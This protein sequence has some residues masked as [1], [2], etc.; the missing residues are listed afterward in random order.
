MATS[1]SSRTVPDST[2]GTEPAP[3]MDLTRLAKALDDAA[4]EGKAIPQLTQEHPEL[5]ETDAYKI[6]RLVIQ[7]RIARGEHRVGAKMGLT[8]RAKARQMGVDRVIWGRLTNVMRAEEGAELMLRGRVHPRVEP[9]VAF[10]LKTSLAGRVSAVEALAAVEAVAPAVE[11]IDSR[12]QDFKFNL[13]DVVAD[14]ASSSGFILGAPRP[15]TTDVSNLGI[16]LWVDGRPVQVGSSAAILG[17]PIRS[18]IAA[19]QLVADGGETLSAGDVVLA[20][21]ATEAVP[22]RGRSHVK[23]EIHNL[24]FVSFGVERKS[25]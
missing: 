12:Y 13:A 8:S 5:D 6:Q 25:S 20:G 22:L 11:I 24:G 21:A 3:A 17:H 7:H 14:N 15:A 2:G 16:I 10:I 18:L 9:E 23:A 19:A 4:R 1:R